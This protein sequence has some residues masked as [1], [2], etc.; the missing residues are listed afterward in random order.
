[1]RQELRR[2]T[3][4]PNYLSHGQSQGRAQYNPRQPPFNAIDEPG[5]A[6]PVPSASISRP[7]APTV[8]HRPAGPSLLSQEEQS[9]DTPSQRSAQPT[10]DLGRRQRTHLQRLAL[11]AI[12]YLESEKLQHPTV[13]PPREPYPTDTQPIPEV[14]WKLVAE[15]K[16]LPTNSLTGFPMRNELNQERFRGHFN[17]SNGILRHDSPLYK[18]AGNTTMFSQ[19]VWQH[20]MELPKRGRIF[21]I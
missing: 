2:Q 16:K 18:Y 14:V 5:T 20:L 1:M 6:A 21:D 8:H 3:Q 7:P 12:G 10:T 9:Q 4:S 11:S 17:L 15:I 19:R 13:E